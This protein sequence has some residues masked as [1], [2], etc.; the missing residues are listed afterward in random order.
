MR[1]GVYFCLACKSYVSAPD[2]IY[3]DRGIFRS[4]KYIIGCKCTRS[5]AIITK[6]LSEKFHGK[7]YW[8]SIEPNKYYRH[9]TSIQVFPGVMLELCDENDP[10]LYIIDYTEDILRRLTIFLKPS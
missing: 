10:D 2:D 1:G 3:N 8:L 5:Y 7:V 4:K 9:S 6:T